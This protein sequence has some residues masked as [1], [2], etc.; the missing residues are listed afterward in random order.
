MIFIINFIIK[1]LS[2]FNRDIFCELYGRLTDYSIIES[3]ANSFPEEKNR[4]YNC[5]EAIL[6]NVGFKVPDI[7]L[8]NNSILKFPNIEEYFSPIVFNNNDF[9]KIIS[10]IKKLRKA[11]FLLDFYESVTNAST[12][13]NFLTN[14]LIGNT[15]RD[16]NNL[17]IDFEYID[18][19]N[20]GCIVCKDNIYLNLLLST[21]HIADILNIKDSILN[22]IISNLKIK[23]YW[24]MD[25]ISTTI[26]LS[27]YI[28]CDFVNL[29]DVKMIESLF[30]I[31]CKGYV[32]KLR[33]ELEGEPTEEEINNALVDISAL[34][35]DISV[36]YI[37]PNIEIFDV[38]L[39]PN[40]EYLD[41]IFKKFLKVERFTIL[42]LNGG[43]NEY[44]REKYP[45]LN[46][47]FVSFDYREDLPDV[48]IIKVYEKI[49]DAIQDSVNE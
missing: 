13:L 10:S 20:L 5:V 47:K 4:I 48:K 37:D 36:K 49:I 29:F 31:K 21:A 12:I 15:T 19:N 41:I 27:N 43:S 6:S 1:M 40:D 23:K 34:T 11:V 46:F 7:Q 35:R 18:H 33:T 44:L 42:V 3:V 16:L 38:I 14:F 17:C 9:V 26:D 30:T 8:D 45:N 39:Y 24:C 28:L 22:L 2:V 25:V 32:M